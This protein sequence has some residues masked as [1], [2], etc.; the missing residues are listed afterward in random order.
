MVNSIN[1]SRIHK[2][3]DKHKII[4]FDIFDTLIKRDCAKPEEVFD[5]LANHVYQKF[6]IRDFANARKK[7]EGIARSRYNNEE[8]T[9]DEIY[10]ILEDDYC[11]EIL[12]KIKDMEMEIEYQLCSVNP[13]MLPV[14]NYCYE[15]KKKIIIVSDMYL[16]KSFI[17]KILK[18]CNIKYDELF[19]SSSL[20]LR[21][22][23][24]KLYKYIINNLKISSKEILHIGDNFKSDY[25]KARIVGIHSK[26]IPVTK[27]NT[28]FKVS[29]MKD[30]DY[31][32]FIA[33]VNNHF[34]YNQNIKNGLFYQ[35]GIE[36]L[37]P[38]LFGFCKW[39][40]RQL[41]ENKCKKV[42]FLSRDGKIIKDIYEKIFD[43]VTENKYMFASRR[44]LIVPTLWLHPELN[45]IKKA[46][47][48][49]RLIT[50]RQFL[51]RIGLYDTNGIN[52]GIPFDEYFN[53]DTLCNNDEFL[54]IYK[55]QIKTR[56]IENSIVQFNNL[57]Q[58]LSQID[59]SGTV[60]IV[61]IGWN[62]SMQKA[63]KEFCD[64]ADIAANIIGFYVGCNPDSDF[65]KTN[66]NIVKGFMFDDKH[67]S[68]LYKL[69]FKN[70]ISLFEVFFTANHG[71]V[72]GYTKSEQEIKPILQKWEYNNEESVFNKIQDIQKGAFDICD[73]LCNYKYLSFEER[74]HWYIINMIALGCYPSC[75]VASSFGNLYMIDD[76]KQYFARIRRN[77][78]YILKPNKMVSD[79]I[80]AP[81]KIGFLKRLFKLKL[82]YNNLITRIRRN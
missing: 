3:I 31:E 72:L 5:I 9:I 70:F 6:K 2:L 48:W 68:E 58:Y 61:D 43:N 47:S 55:N 62:G 15:N 33:I 66:S 25:L 19:L 57:K 54:T 52:T 59:F 27:S 37:G 41:V 24:G 50:L 44:A 13:M 79:L 18:K 17:E 10:K 4:S 64:A 67:D 12:N 23:S 63:L 65:V 28:L 21:K 16:N 22:S 26:W 1:Y 46:M 39:L 77:S 45:D 56:M 32:N 80:Y 8:V 38:I 76:E 11:A 60:A 35:S 74:T 51:S 53:F 78:E 81:W 7:A 75:N 34:S 30:K 71:T 69:Y 73:F 49:P 20:R 29:K 36:A 14:M 42:F 82:P 40:N